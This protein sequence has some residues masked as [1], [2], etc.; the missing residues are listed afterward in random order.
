[1][2]TERMIGLLKEL[3]VQTYTWATTVC[4]IKTLPAAPILYHPASTHAERLAG[5]SESI[6]ILF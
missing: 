3:S 2:E 5:I 1:M 6:K 4:L